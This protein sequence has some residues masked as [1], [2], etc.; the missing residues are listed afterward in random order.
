MT[1]KTSKNNISKYQSIKKTFLWAAVC[2]LIGEIIVGALIILTQGWT[3]EIG[4]IQATFFLVAIALLIGINN[5]AMMEKENNIV[6][7]S[8]TASLICNF[9]WLIVAILLIWGI[10][11]A[12]D[13]M[14]DI[15]SVAANITAAGFWISNVWNIEESV[16]PVKPLK[17]TS[18]VCVL[19]CFIY[20]LITTFNYESI[21]FDTRWSAL[22]GLAGLA[23]IITAIIAAIVS[24]TNIKKHNISA[25]DVTNSSDIQ[26]TIQDLV[27]KE[28]QARMAAQG[29][30]S[31]D[32]HSS[33]GSVASVG[34]HD[35]MTHDASTS[36][37]GP[38]TQTTE[39]HGDSYRPGEPSNG[40]VNHIPKRDLSAIY[41]DIKKDDPPKVHLDNDSTPKDGSSMSEET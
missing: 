31:T 40:S 26:S 35:S 6:R 36:N 32:G 33:T 28:V 29:V 22:S 8:A 24:R 27:E 38:A 2:I 30:A 15:L 3:V 19:Y 5:F 17:I 16:A 10:N 25:K 13:V 20:A 11:D 4:K 37:Q 7:W 21:G 12:N 1:S 23:F 18:V 9:V 34:E 14:R 39:A 41:P